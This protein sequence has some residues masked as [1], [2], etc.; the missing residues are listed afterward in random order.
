MPTVV[1][2]IGL[3]VSDLEAATAFYKLVGFEDGEISRLP[4]RHRWLREIVGL[5]APDMEVT[6]LSLGDLSLEL[7]R[8]HEPH[9]APRTT[10]N[11]YDAG[12]AHI[13]FGVDDIDVEYER[14]SAAGVAFI[15]APVTITDGDFAGVQAVYAYD[16]DGN[17]IEL[18]SSIG[19]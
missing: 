6:F 13:A 2:H 16:P 7:V 15:S 9:G 14:L 10:L 11:L 19:P 17:C 1:H 4:L 18:L 5:E 3:T 12:S 8:Y